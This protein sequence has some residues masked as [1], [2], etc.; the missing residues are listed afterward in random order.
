MNVHPDSKYVVFGGGTTSCFPLAINLLATLRC[1]VAHP[2]LQRG[3]AMC[4]LTHRTRL[5]QQSATGRWLLA[6]HPSVEGVL[7][8]AKDHLEF[9]HG[10]QS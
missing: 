9:T 3:G 6:T 5:S 10:A 1:F 4:E 2:L 8:I 7:L